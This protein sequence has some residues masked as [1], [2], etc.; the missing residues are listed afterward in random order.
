MSAAQLEL[1]CVDC[2]EPTFPRDARCARHSWD[3]DAAEAYTQIKRELAEDADRE[4][5]DGGA[6]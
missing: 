6:A 2:N 1:F 4:Q 3:H 5:I